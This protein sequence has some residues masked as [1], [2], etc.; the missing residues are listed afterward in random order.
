MD[1]PHFEWKRFWVPSDESAHLDGSYL[2][3][4]DSEYG[5]IVNAKALPIS[6][7]REHQCL[8]LLGE[9]GMGKT[10]AMKDARQ[11]IE[12]RASSAGEGFLWLDLNTCGSDSTLDRYLFDNSEFQSWRQGSRTLNLFLDSLDECLLRIETVALRLVRELR[13]GD[14]SKLRL[15]IACRTAEWPRTVRDGLA[16]LYGQAVHVYELAP[17][18]KCDVAKAAESIGPEADRFLAELD[19]REAAPFASKPVTLNMPL[20][21]F[22][23]SGHLPSD[24]ASLYEEGCKALCEETSQTRTGPSTARKLSVEQRIQVARRIA[25]IMAFCQR[26]SIP[27]RGGAGQAEPTDLT[28]ADIVGTGQREKTEDSEVE[29]TEETAKEALNSGLFSGRGPDHLGWRHHTYL[30]FLASE[31]VLAH[32]FSSEQLAE[33]IMHPLDTSKVVPQLHGV[34]AWLAGKK[35]DIFNRIC[36]TDPRVLLAADIGTLDDERKGRLVDSFLGHVEARTAPVDWNALRYFSRLK[37]NGLESRLRRQIGNRSLSAHTR[38]VAIDIAEEC[39]CK[40]LQDLL[41]EIALNADE[42][43]AVREDAAAAIGRIADDHVKLLLRPLVDGDPAKTNDELK[44]HALSALY[45][46]L[47][48]EEIFKLMMAPVNS[49]HWG[50]YRHFVDRLVRGLTPEDLPCALEWAVNFPSQHR[51]YYFGQAR[52]EILRAAR[53]HLDKPAVLAAFAKVARARMKISEPILDKKLSWPGSLDRRRLIQAII[54]VEC[55]AAEE[56]SKTAPTSSRLHWWYETRGESPLVR[57]E[58]LAWVLE[59]FLATKVSAFRQCWAELLKVVVNS[60]CIGRCSIDPVIEAAEEAPDLYQL[61]PDAL[62]SIE[63]DSER[64]R[65]LKEDEQANQQL[66]QQPTREGPSLAERMATRLSRCEHEVVNAFPE[67]LHHMAFG[68]QLS[69]RADPFNVPV[70]EFPGWRDIGDSTRRTILNF[71]KTY[72]ANLEVKPSA[73]VGQEFTISWPVQVAYLT[74]CLLEQLEPEWLSHASSSA[75]QRWAAIVVERES[76]LSEPTRLLDRALDRAPEEAISKFTELIDWEDRTHQC[77]TFARRL[78]PFWNRRV[79]ECLLAQARIPGRAPATV[80][81]LLDLLLSKGSR[82]GM[83]F[84]RSIVSAISPSGCDSDELVREIAEPLLRHEPA[85]GWPCV[86]KIVVDNPALGRD[87]VIRTAKRLHP[88]FGVEQ[89]PWADRLT[90]Y[91]VGELYTWLCREFPHSEDRDRTRGGAMSDRELVADF[92]DYLLSNLSSRSTP[93]AVEQLTRIND[94]PGSP[95]IR[96][97]IAHARRSVLETNWNSPTPRELLKMAENTE[98]RWI[99]SAQQLQAVVLESLARYQEELR[100]EI[101][102]YED[103]WNEVE[104]KTWRPK[105]E[106][107]ISNNIAR[108]LRRDLTKRGVI[109]NREVQIRPSP[110]GQRTDIHVDAVRRG[111]GGVGEAPLKVIIEVKGCWNSSLQTAMEGQLKNRYLKDSDCQHGIY[112]V[113]WF[114]CEHWDPR[115]SRCSEARSW[116]WNLEDART[117]LEKQATSISDDRC[118]LAAVILDAR[119]GQ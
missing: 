20:R 59:C 69:D 23:R 39:E 22:E 88:S 73:Q 16:E 112:L 21:M 76:W 96:H 45:G 24:L 25:A 62:G 44:G 41:V 48:V 53:E 82:D 68:D 28:I 77:A 27:Q 26:D 61:F 97:L 35:Q 118:S 13:P 10:T 87:I 81:N 72:L 19:Q 85:I 46:L 2:M 117:Y 54:D 90:E 58:D 50:A 3:D 108:H 5:R 113:A 12:Q 116:N 7:L 42:E 33:L 34:A 105:R 109:I 30:E 83:E 104:A 1:K 75:W 71:G 52:D 4:P 111:P 98:E 32:G 114:N 47:K 95:D 74:L 8:V 36:A 38:R 99:A 67:L 6:A 84:A 79:E 65:Q 110:Q 100:N 18:R 80:G 31:Y 57:E 93:A 9:P 91:D 107:S 92:R 14:P 70:Y 40:D 56:V 94:Q 11:E 37:H 78:I 49:H 106:D 115:D 17:L 51:D 43:T 102:A 60:I 66:F 29:M 63:I 103:L 55:N 101:P 15:R 86:R 119:L 64:A 89:R